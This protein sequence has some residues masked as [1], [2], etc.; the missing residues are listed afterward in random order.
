[1]EQPFNGFSLFEMLFDNGRDVFRFHATIPST[2]RQHPDGGAHIALP[3]TLAGIDSDARDRVRLKGFQH[4]SRT[5]TLAIHILANQYL[6]GRVQCRLPKNYLPNP[7]PRLA[8]G[9]VK[10]CSICDRSVS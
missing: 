3:L 7:L 8:V 5:V 9:N 6:A 2:I 4:L 1:M 10:Q